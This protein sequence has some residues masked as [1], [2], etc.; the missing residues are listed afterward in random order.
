LLFDSTLAACKP[1]AVIVRSHILS[2]I[3][4][5]K[6]T[7]ALQSAST[8]HSSVNSSS[9]QEIPHQTA[10]LSNKGQAVLT[11]QQS[12]RPLVE[13]AA[14]QQPVATQL[15]LLLYPQAPPGAGIVTH[16][17]PL[18]APPSASWWPSG[19][20]AA[21]ADSSSA[22]DASSSSSR[23]G[24]QPL[25]APGGGGGRLHC[26]SRVSTDLAGRRGVSRGSAAMQ[27]RCPSSITIRLVGFLALLPA[28][29][30]STVTADPWSCWRPCCRRR[31]C[32]RLSSSAA[33]PSASGPQR[34]SRVLGVIDGNACNRS[35]AVSKTVS[36]AVN[37][38]D[39]RSHNRTVHPA[40]ETCRPRPP[41]SQQHST[42]QY[43][44]VHLYKLAS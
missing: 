27:A 29:R 14:Q 24:R 44:A 23:R 9:Q 22:S 25:A 8:Q 21:A 28:T 16:T 6:T 3:L 18:I 39:S 31:R 19:L 15:H 35:R 32:C 36:T 13:A 41:L 4:S 5:H 34:G 20:R 12:T 43:K 30:V 37:A 42:R 1:T 2:H 38:S 26:S 40:A 17:R 33:G 11:N 10:A 7:R